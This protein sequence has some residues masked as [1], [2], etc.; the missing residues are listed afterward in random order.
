MARRVTK[1]CARISKRSS[2]TGSPWRATRTRGSRGRRARGRPSQAVHQLRNVALPHRCPPQHPC[3]HSEPLE[4]RH[5]E[6]SRHRGGRVGGPRGSCAR[7]KGR[8]ALVRHSDLQ[9]LRGM[10]LQVSCGPLRG[11]R[12]GRHKTGIGVPSTVRHTPHRDA[13]AP[14]PCPSAA[15][16]V[17]GS[18]KTT[19]PKPRS[20]D[21]TNRVVPHNR[22]PP[23]AQ[24]IS[25]WRPPSLSVGF[26][27]HF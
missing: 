23:T 12:R 21:I 2:W 26:A 13:H 18:P 3:T 14:D 22:P 19:T 10:P 20:N 24:Q 8:V 25:A 4:T 5:R 7:A 6:R 15:H 11:C 27:H 17:Q 1:W 16:V 9:H